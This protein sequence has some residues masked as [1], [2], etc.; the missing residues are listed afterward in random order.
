M[1]NEMGAAPI[2]EGPLP[3]EL[4]NPGDTAHVQIDISD[5]LKHAGSDGIL[6]KATL[7]IL[8]VNLTCLDSVSPS[9]CLR[10]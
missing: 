3:V 8:I 4:T 1:A 7:R 5:N 10:S 6:E 9:K 2:P